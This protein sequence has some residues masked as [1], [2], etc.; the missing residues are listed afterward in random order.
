[1]IEDLQI[2]GLVRPGAA[3][4]EPNR[5]R[6]VAL[7]EIAH[8]FRCSRAGDDVLGD[9]VPGDVHVNVT[10]AGIAQNLFDERSVVLGR[11]QPHAPSPYAND[12]RVWVP[13][14]EGSYWLR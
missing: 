3:L 10:E 7:Y 2:L 12:G 5:K 9:F 4:S 13:L 11:P 8:G 14:E 6:P 1:M